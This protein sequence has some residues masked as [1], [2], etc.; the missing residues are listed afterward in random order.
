M[1]LI[2]TDCDPD[3][4]DLPIPGNDDGIRSI[5]LVTSMLADAILQGRAEAPTAKGDSESAA[6][7]QE[8]ATDSSAATGDASN[9]SNGEESGE[10]K[11]E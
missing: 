4:V 11:T 5:E 7:K 10:Q 1:G 2:D 8:V 6:D 9:E 3:S